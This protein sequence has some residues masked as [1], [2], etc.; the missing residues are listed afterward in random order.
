MSLP[1]S[2]I[3]LV[4]VMG[5]TGRTA[6]SKISIKVVGRRELP[7]GSR[8]FLRIPSLGNDNE[9]LE[10]NVHE[11]DPLEISSID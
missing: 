3:W 10:L 9:I 7:L 4:L 11:V 8:R 2:V 1:V 5:R 6:C